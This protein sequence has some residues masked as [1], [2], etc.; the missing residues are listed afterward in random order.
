MRHL[1]LLAFLL[2]VPGIALS[3][4]LG[5]VVSLG[6]GASFNTPTS[7][8]ADQ[9]AGGWGAMAGAKFAIPL[10]DITGAIEYMDFGKKENSGVSS[11]ATMWG[12]T[13]G[14]RFTLIPLLYLGAE[15]G[16]FGVTRTTTV[17]GQE[18]EGKITYGSYGPIIGFNIL[19]LDLNAR[20]II[21]DK[22]TFTSIRAIY[23]F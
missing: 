23:W 18:S 5:D 15:I 22:A 19:G 1:V 14:G 17:G 8:F 3:G 2:L 6:V 10:I 11:D 20:Y 16:S 13:A 4:V 21:M 9:V 7:D 12:F